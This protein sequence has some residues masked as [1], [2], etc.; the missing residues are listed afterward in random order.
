[1]VRKALFFLALLQKRCWRGLTMEAVLDKLV[2]GSNVYI[3]Q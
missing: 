1:L 2:G 3:A